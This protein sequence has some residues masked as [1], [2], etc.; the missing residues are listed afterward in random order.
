MTLLTIIYIESPAQHGIPPQ[1]KWM[2][3]CPAPAHTE[4]I[5]RE[6]AG[7]CDLFVTAGEHH[8]RIW[9]FRRPDNTNNEPASLKYKAGAMGKVTH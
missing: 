2:D 3:Y 6:H 7:L 9:S 8:L 5:T 1:I 4:Y